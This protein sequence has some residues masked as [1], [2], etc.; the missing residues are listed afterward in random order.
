MYGVEQKQT[1]N[2]PEN[3]NSDVVVVGSGGVGGVG[4]GGCDGGGGRGGG[5]VV[6]FTLNRCFYPDPVLL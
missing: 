2:M 1:G 5:A 3:Q 4:V 6:L